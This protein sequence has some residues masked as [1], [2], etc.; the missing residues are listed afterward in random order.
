MNPQ[1]P[2]I[3]SIRERNGRWQLRYR[4][5]GRET[6][7]SFDTFDSAYS[8]SVQ[9]SALGSAGRAAAMQGRTMPLVDVATLWA[10]TRGFS[11]STR[12]T[13]QSHM[14]NHILP[15]FGH[16]PL[17]EILRF[18]VEAWLKALPLAPTTA[19]RVLGVLRGITQFG[20]G[21]GWIDQ[22]PTFRIHVN[23]ANRRRS[24]VLPT[25]DDIEELRLVMP[26]FYRPLVDVM[27]YGGCSISEAAGLRV[28]DLDFE[29]RILHVR[30]A[31][32]EVADGPPII[33]PIMKTSTRD[34]DVPVIPERVW[35][36]L[37]TL[38]Q[39]DPSTLVAPAPRG[40][41]LHPGNFRAR[42]F[43][44]AV[45]TVFH[46]AH[47]VRPHGLRHFAISLWL[48]SGMNST[49][50]ADFAGH[51]TD[52]MTRSIYGQA[53]PR[54]GSKLEIDT[55][56]AVSAGQIYSRLRPAPLGEDLELAA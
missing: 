35:E 48:A 33:S 21:R 46:D 41:I 19:Q 29:R 49:E 12:K 36:R 3:G 4:S 6:S 40:G 28:V 17:A 37:R 32:K 2:L 54:T 14:R 18:E 10:P 55:L 51:A 26:S 9:L 45:E 1:T 50:A 52:E 38:S 27:A 11:E 25:V 23:G 31:R 16:L 42:V 8:H 22:D 15:T 43:Q 20:V 53:L 47:E 24:L 34:R 39:H 5:L 30:A 13:N 7:K 44:P 56:A